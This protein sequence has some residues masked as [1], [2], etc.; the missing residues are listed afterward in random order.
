MLA[1]VTHRMF[2]A[3]IVIAGLTGSAAAQDEA[4]FREAFGGDWYVFDN[5]VSAADQ[6]CRMALSTEGD[7]PWT[8]SARNCTGALSDLESWSIENGQILLQAADVTEPLAAVGGNQF[9]LSGELAATGNTIIVE[10]Q[11]G[12]GAAA[13]IAAALEEHTCFYRG[14]SS[15]CATSEELQVPQSAADGADI[16]TL[17]P[18]NVRA[19]PR[20]DA[21]IVGT[22]PEGSEITANQCMLAS[23]GVWCRADFSGET[24]FFAKNA[25]RQDEWPVTT[26]DVR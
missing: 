14:L 10:R 18:L 4:A 25:V 2:A 5:S 7:T 26:F 3:A 6:I 9:R 13:R 8:A 22:V 17:A 11:A 1:S 20:R 24:G 21:A 12:D 15:E 19:L 16:I 23:D